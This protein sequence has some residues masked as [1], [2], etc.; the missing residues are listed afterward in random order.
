[1]AINVALPTVLAMEIK[2]TPHIQLNLP[3]EGFTLQEIKKEI[4]DRAWEVLEQWS[5]KGIHGTPDH[6]ILMDE[7][8]VE[9]INDSELRD[10]LSNSLNFSVIFKGHLSSVFYRLLN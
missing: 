8:D 5:P 9:I 3:S 6:I 4:F 1:M 10:R 7:F 2:Y